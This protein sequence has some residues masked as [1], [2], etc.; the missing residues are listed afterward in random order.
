VTADGP[1]SGTDQ[2]SSWATVLLGAGIVGGLLAIV[3]GV[4]LAAATPPVSPVLVVASATSSPGSASGTPVP[5]ASPSSTATAPATPST[6][7][8]SPAPSK[9][10]KASRSPKAK[11]APTGQPSY[12][13][14]A[15]SPG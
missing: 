6:P 4:A 5:S 10:P 13:P 15:T 3:A 14:T 9:S 8:S 7:S 11:Q 12:I 2:G 1:E